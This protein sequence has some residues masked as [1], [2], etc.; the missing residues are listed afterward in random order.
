ML[1]L[2]LDMC[3]DKTMHTREKFAYSC[4]VHTCMNSASHNTKSESIFVLI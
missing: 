1:N 2:Q 4:Y 3:A